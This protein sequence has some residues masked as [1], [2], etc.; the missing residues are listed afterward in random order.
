[1]YDF[2]RPLSTSQRPPASALASAPNLPAASLPV[3]AAAAAKWTDPHFR[4]GISYNP[5]D[6]SANCR[7]ASQVAQDVSLL[8]TADGY[9]VV[10]TYGADCFQIRNTLDALD[11]WPN[12]RLFAGV[13]DVNNVV[14]ETN[15]LIRKLFLPS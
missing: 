3:A 2:H 14:G 8:I 7:S 6:A 4:L 10:R 5:Y 1:M 9:D 11:K 12:T 15:S 13:W